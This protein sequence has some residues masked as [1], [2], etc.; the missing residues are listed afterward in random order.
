MSELLTRE[1]VL[2]HIA[3]TKDPTNSKN[4]TLFNPFET[5]TTMMSNSTNP[6]LVLSKLR[7]QDRI[8]LASRIIHT[9]S[10]R[11][12]LKYA[13]KQAVDNT[14]FSEHGFAFVSRQV[15]SDGIPVNGDLIVPRMPRSLP[16]DPPDLSRSFLFAACEVFDSSKTSKF[17]SRRLS[18]VLKLEKTQTHDVVKIPCPQSPQKAYSLLRYP[19]QQFSTPLHSQRICRR[20]YSGKPCDR[21]RCSFVHVKPMSHSHRAHTPH[22]PRKSK[23]HRG[24]AGFKSAKYGR[25]SNH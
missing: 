3:I 7:R 17:W 20:F 4:E 25:T 24:S 5:Y 19:F 18:D 11:K 15:V 6:G 13:V 22:A 1:H 14:H 21:G 23:R 2:G 16:S 12:F 10:V 9:K 8:T